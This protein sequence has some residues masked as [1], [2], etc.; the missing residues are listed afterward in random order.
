MLIELSGGRVLTGDGELV[1][2]SLQIAD[3]T[4]RALGDDGLPRPD[5]RLDVTGCLVLPGIVDLHGDAFERQL[6]PR[7]GVHFPYDVALVESDRQMLANGITTAF[8]GLTWSWEPGLRG[9][10]AARD[11]RRA[12]DRMRPHLACDTRLHLRHETFNLAAEAEVVEWI[13]EGAVDLL[14]FNDHVGDI[15]EDLERPAKLAK[16][17][18]RT[19]LSSDGFR[20]LVAEVAGRADE[21]G[22]SIERIAATARAAGVPM[23]SHDDPDPD[24]RAVAHALGC[25]ISEFPKDE[26]TARAARD[27]GASVVL[28]APNVLRG[29]S[30]A[31]RLGAREAIAVGL[32]DALTTDY[33]YPSTLL[34]AF[35]LAEDGMMPF[36]EA[37]RLLS[38]GPAAAVGLNDRGLLEEG[39][40]ADVVVVRR[41]HGTPPG[42]AATFAA[43]RL[44]HVRDLFPL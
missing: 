15:V 34:A 16:Y 21:V 30:H 36:A 43:G 26:A 2:A 5:R 10:E 38:A 18:D 29:G 40:R 1:E 23:A 6:M 22:C 25:T 14:A 33:Y 19:G 3:G 24:A 11:F 13:R 12:L 4:I 39:R 20:A 9:T 31:G 32:C 7:P 42:V 8:H 27:A 44:V 37:W 35:R 17:V 41:P 28:G